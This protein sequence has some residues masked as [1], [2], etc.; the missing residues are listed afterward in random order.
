[1]ALLVQAV[2]N[3]DQPR[4]SPPQV[5]G[6]AHP[7]L[8]ESSTDQQ[9]HKL[10]S[11]KLFEAIESWGCLLGNIVVIDSLWLPQWLRQWRIHLHWR[12][13]GFDPWVGKI[14][15]RRTWQPTPVPLPRKSHGQRSP[16]GGKRVGHDLATIDSLQNK[17]TCPPGKIFKG[18]PR[19]HAAALKDSGN[20][21]I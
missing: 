4:V 8:Q 12:R 5:C 16:W 17:Q 21:E 19:P 15:W 3:R 20:C 10:N 2:A 18:A 11:W 13:P 7:R 14:P 6:Q 9:A 1:M